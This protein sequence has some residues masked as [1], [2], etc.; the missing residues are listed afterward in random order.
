MQVKRQFFF[1]SYLAFEKKQL[2]IELFNLNRHVPK[3]Q[4]YEKER[5]GQASH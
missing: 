2:G 1:G 5:M 4:Y 3:E